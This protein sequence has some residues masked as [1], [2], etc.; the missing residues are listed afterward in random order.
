M[1]LCL[2]YFLPVHCLNILSIIHIVKQFNNLLSRTELWPKNIGLL[3]ANMSY[4][5]KKRKKA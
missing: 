4:G 5:Y 3:P 2:F 1:N